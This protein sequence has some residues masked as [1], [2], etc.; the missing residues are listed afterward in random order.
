MVVGHVHHRHVGGVGGLSLPWMDG[1]G[2]LP[3]FVVIFVPLSIG[4]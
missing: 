2:P 3:L 1:G 4:G